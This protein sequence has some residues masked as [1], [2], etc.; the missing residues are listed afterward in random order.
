[1]LSLRAVL[2]LVLAVMELLVAQCALNPLPEVC[3]SVRTW[4]KNSVLTRT[5]SRQSY[6]LV[7]EVGPT[8][9]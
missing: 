7:G 8:D 5:R 6:C 3:C 2:V 4:F 1:M 9:T